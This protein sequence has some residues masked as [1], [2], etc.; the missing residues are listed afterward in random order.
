MVLTS[1][2]FLATSYVATN[3]KVEL[4]DINMFLNNKFVVEKHVIS[5]GEY[6]DKIPLRKIKRTTK[7]KGQKIDFERM[8]KACKLKSNR[9]NQDH[10]LK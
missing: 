3:Q 8:K 7:G 4:C 1:F 5:G 2:F 9:H 10:P 6:S